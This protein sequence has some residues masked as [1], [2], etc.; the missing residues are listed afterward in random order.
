MVDWAQDLLQEEYAPYYLYRQKNQ[1]GNFENVG[2]AK[3]GMECLYNIASWTKP[4]P[5]SPP[6][7]GA[8]PSS[9][10]AKKTVS[11]EF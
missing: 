8:S 2:Y 10:T 3:E 11:R 4:R 5:F 7:R 6:A 9:M 1:L